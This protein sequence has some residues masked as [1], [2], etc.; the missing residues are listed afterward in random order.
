[1][2]ALAAALQESKLRNLAP[3]AGDRDSVGVLQQRPSQGWGNGDV[4][5]LQDVFKATT[6]FLQHL[7]KIDGWQTM[8]L[9]DAVQTVQV[10]AD[11]SKYAQHE[12]KASALAQAL[13][14]R[15]P[16]AVTCHFGKPTQVAAA[17]TVATRLAAELP[18]RKPAISGPVITVPGARWQTV[19]W[20]V[21][22]AD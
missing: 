12:K 2:L 10:S 3:G 13:L 21:A 5:N 17:H 22:Y 11:G 9:A 7:V 15:V 4:N 19:A 8:P 6:E 16:K 18:V 14:G 1:T 20:L